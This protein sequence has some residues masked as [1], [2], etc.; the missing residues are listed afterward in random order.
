[1]AGGQSRFIDKGDV[2]IWKILRNHRRLQQSRPGSRGSKLDLG[3]K[4]AAGP[5]LEELEYVNKERAF[6]IRK[7]SEPQP[8]ALAIL[9]TSQPS[10][11]QAPELTL[12][13]QKVKVPATG[14]GGAAEQSQPTRATAGKRKEAKGLRTSSLASK[15]P[16]NE[17]RGSP[18]KRKPGK[19]KQIS[20]K[21]LGRPLVV[22]LPSTGQQRSDAT[23]ADLLAQLARTR[24][25][26]RRKN[27]TFDI[28]DLVQGWEQAQ[29]R[30]K[31]QVHGQA[32]IATERSIGE[33]TSTTLGQQPQ[34]SEF[35][36]LME[37]AV[38]PSQM[39][40]LEQPYPPITDRTSA[41]ASGSQP[42]IA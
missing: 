20:L 12:T 21:A 26:G 14:R 7:Q 16:L 9:H 5:V 27:E 33:V 13:G 15:A 3:Y 35:D 37:S 36:P 10:G 8:V 31:T 38:L 22:Q 40:N 34:H 23:Q 32:R 17:P 2:I 30:R 42:L 11:R 39:F 4:R 41:L 19:V 24:Y 1:M 25:I 29:L 28:S 18:A 6:R